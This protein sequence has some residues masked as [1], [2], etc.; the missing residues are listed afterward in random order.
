MPQKPRSHLLALLMLAGATRTLAFENGPAIEIRRTAAEIKIDGDLSDP[1]WQGAS[2]VTTWWETNPG[3]NLEPKVRN[4]AR[5]VYDGEFL[6]AAF[7]FDDPEPAKVRAPVGDRDVVPSYTDYGGV[8]LDGKND[9]KSAQM[10]LA[11]ARGIQYDAITNDA[12]GEDNT[13]DFFWESAGKITERGWQLEMRI[14]FSSIRYQGTD[15]KQWGILLYRNR[16]REFRYQFFSSRLPRDRNCFVCNVRPL[17]GL[18]GLPGGSHWVAAPFATAGKSREAVDGA[19]SR[20]EGQPGDYDVGADLKWIPNPDTVVDGTINPDFSQIESDTAQIGVNERFAIFQPE[21]RPFF[22][23]SVDLLSTPIQ[24]VYTRTFTA[25]TWGART[26]GSFGDTKYTALVGQDKGGGL[27]LL[28]GSNSSDFGNQDYKSWVAIGRVR[29]DF[30]DS[31]ASVLYTGREIQGGGSN[32]V[33]GPDFQWR[34]TGSDV[35]TGQLLWSFSKTPNRPDLASEWDG[36]DLQ[37]HAG[38]LWWNRTLQHWDF[39]GEYKDFSD[40][41]RAD[42]GFVPQVGYRSGYGETGYTFRPKEG[43]VRRLRLFT[44]GFYSE[45]SAGELLQ[46]QVVPGFGMDALWNSFVRVEF[47]FDKSRAVTRVFER[48]QIRPTIE[49]R[50]G[51]IFAYLMLQGQFG[52]QVDF[53]GDRAGKGSSL[54]VQAIVRPTDHLA[55]TLDASRRTLD[56]DAAFGKPAGKLFTAE[57]G[58]VKAVYTFNARSW[59]RLIAQQV[60]TTFDPAIALDDVSRHDR[61]F[62]GSA[63]F[64]YKLNWQTVLYLGYSE[65]RDLD[66]NDRLAPV[67]KQLFF[68]VS[69]ALRG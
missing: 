6:Y 39:Y 7:E 27:V 9:G 55:F 12:S 32:R 4:L 66:E 13:P 15:P 18:A 50:P 44:Y 10:F 56:V 47:V 61:R 45:D 41:F 38:Y 21:R 57:V 23:E 3:D 29:H 19:G 31:F 48:R 1:G 2:E 34:P 16:P 68:K 40:G 67:G 63:V 33:F 14:P 62:G 20:L 30:G 43:A 11:N 58:R 37:G 46:Q 5:L 24:A 60:S 54:T 28:P 17:T 8:I 53:G 26:S 51:K 65:G 52:D 69:Y 59:L 22:L 49:M 64:A 42:D 36:R 35:V 25:P